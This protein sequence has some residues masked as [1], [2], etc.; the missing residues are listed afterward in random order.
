MNPKIGGS[1]PSQFEIFSVA[2]LWHFHKCV[3]NEC[4]CPRTVNISN[5]NFTSKIIKLH[6]CPEIVNADPFIGAHDQLMASMYW[7][8]SF[9]NIYTLSYDTCVCNLTK[10]VFVAWFAQK[11]S[12][13]TVLPICISTTMHILDICDTL[14]C[15]AFMDTLHHTMTSSNRNIFRV[16]GHLCGEFTGRQWIPRTKASDA[17]LWC[18]LWSAP[19]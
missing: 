3:E 14:F 16:T 6:A 13:Q 1:S 4:C 15:M 12:M 8:R 18:F 10:I 2:K 19:D 7:L 5:V 9:Y 17:E 11:R